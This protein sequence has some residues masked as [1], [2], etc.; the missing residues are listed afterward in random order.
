[1][2][3]VKKQADGQY[4]MGYDPE[5]A[6]PFRKITTFTDTDMWMF[7]D[8]IKSTT[9]LIRGAQSDLLTADTARQM[10]ER[11]PRARLTEIPG[12]GHAPTL[13]DEAQVKPIRDFLLAP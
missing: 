6:A 10:T 7:Y 1:V 8:L 12:V 13:M 9:L 3:A 2:H 4:V 11:G 5:L